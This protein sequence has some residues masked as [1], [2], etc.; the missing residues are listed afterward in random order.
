[1]RSNLLWREAEWL[2]GMR[3]VKYLEPKHFPGG[4]K[5][6]P[7]SYLR[8]YC[9]SGASWRTNKGTTRRVGNPKKETRILRAFLPE[10]SGQMMN[11]GASA[12]FSCPATLSWPV[13]W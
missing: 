3:G 8:S 9:R 13:F 6:A 11:E 2:P 12:S 4:P 1:M 7:G 10:Q 5:L